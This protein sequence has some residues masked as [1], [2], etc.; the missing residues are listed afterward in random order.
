LKEFKQIEAMCKKY[1][2]TKTVK[3]Y[4]L[5]ML[6]VD[7]KRSDYIVAIPWYAEDDLDFVEY[8]AFEQM[9]YY[10]LIFSYDKILN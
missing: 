4:I 2:D 1:Y 7:D 5:H 6:K 3:Y 10:A 8:A 9:L